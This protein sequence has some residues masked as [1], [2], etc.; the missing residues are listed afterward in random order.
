MPPPPPEATVTA[1]VTPMEDKPKKFTSK[2][3]M[4]THTS[5]NAERMK[6][7]DKIIRLGAKALKR[8]ETRK[9]KVYKPSK[10]NVHLQEYRKLYPDLKFKDVLKNAKTTYVR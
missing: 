8:Q 10:W 9:N 2:D 1:T 6:S 3:F 7:Y 5:Q 4:Q